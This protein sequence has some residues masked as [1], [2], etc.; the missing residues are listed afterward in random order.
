[1]LMSGPPVQAF[2]PLMPIPSLK[3]PYAM[4]TRGQLVRLTVMRG[5]TRGGSG[6]VALPSRK[7]GSETVTLSSR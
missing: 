5:V 6:G 3:K 1:M 2:H 4:T 7:T